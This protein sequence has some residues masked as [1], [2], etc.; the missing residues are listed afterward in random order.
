[1]D[2]LNTIYRGPRGRERLRNVA[3]AAPVAAKFEDCSNRFNRL[4][5]ALRSRV[6][7][8]IST[9]ADFNYAKF[10]AWANDTGAA[11]KSLDHMLRKASDLRE[12]TLDLLN[13]LYEL[14]LEGI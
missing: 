13:D 4:C 11:T 8:T 9:L 7:S 6:P 5:I 3:K 2:A 12:G 1:M 10:L 14:I